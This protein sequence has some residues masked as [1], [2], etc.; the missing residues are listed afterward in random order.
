[1][2]FR[3]DVHWVNIWR[4]EDAFEL[5]RS[6]NDG[7]EETPT[8][9]LLDPTAAGPVVIPASDHGTDR[10]TSSSSVILSPVAQ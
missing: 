10:R 9:V 2:L 8:A 5:C 7:A 4:D 3:S 1:V 6:I